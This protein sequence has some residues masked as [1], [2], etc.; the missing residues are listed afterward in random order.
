MSGTITE[1]EWRV[2]G[3]TNTDAAWQDIPDHEIEHCDC[4]LAHMQGEAFR[5]YLPAYMVY[6]LGHAQDS[7]MQSAI[8]GSVIFGLTPSKCVPSY[9]ASQYRLLDPRQKEAVAAFL[10]YMAAHAEDDHREDAKQAL[11]FWAPTT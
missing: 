5:Y 8:P 3:I 2:A 4:Q 9:S 10:A 6:A 1:E 7:I 11:A